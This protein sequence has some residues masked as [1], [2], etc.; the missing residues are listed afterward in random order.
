MKA[1][2]KVL[3]VVALLVFIWMA[4]EGIRAYYFARADLV[5]YM[6]V[7]KFLLGP[8]FAVFSV[9]AGGSHFKRWTETL[10]LKAK[11]GGKTDLQGIT[12]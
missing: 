9:A 11:N 6:E 1:G 3:R 12:G 2:I 8:W 7:A 4:V 5:R 10:A